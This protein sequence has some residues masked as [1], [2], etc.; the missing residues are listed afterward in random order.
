VVVVV[1]VPGGVF[2][3]FLGVKHQGHSTFTL[4]TT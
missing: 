1:V 4:G 2:V 3:V